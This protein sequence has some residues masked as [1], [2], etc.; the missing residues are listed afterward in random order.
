MDGSDLLVRQRKLDG[1]IMAYKPQADAYVDASIVLADLAA[2]L[3]DQAAGTASLRTMGTGSTQAAAGNDSRIVGA[4]QTA[5][6]NAASGYAGLDGSTLLATA[7]HGTGT[8]NSTTFLRGDR[9]WATPTVQPTVT[10]STKT[11]T[12]TTTTTDDVILADAAGGAFTITL[13]AASTWTKTL[14]VKRINSGGNAVT[15]DGNASET[16]DGATTRALSQQYE[17]V[18][19]ASN[20]TNLFVL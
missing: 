4:E 14:T 7:Q 5:N 11:T 15:L 1:D 17:S 16:I 12:Y 20:G 3:I 18:T 2:S 10:V 6:K 8:A 19:L 9:T 13:H